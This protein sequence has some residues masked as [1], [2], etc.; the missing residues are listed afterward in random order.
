MVAP[1]NPPMAMQSTAV[2]APDTAPAPDTGFQMPVLIAGG[3]L[4]AA[5]LLVIWLVTRSRRPR[6]SL[7]SSS[8]QDDLRLPPKK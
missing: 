3:L 7:I 4:A 6:G 5:V 1:T 2:A 8:M